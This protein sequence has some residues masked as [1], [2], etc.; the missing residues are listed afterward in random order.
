VWL[1]ST[2]NPLAYVDVYRLNYCTALLSWAKSKNPTFR[3]VNDSIYDAMHRLRVSGYRSVG[4]IAHSL[5]GLMV[6]SYITTVNET[7]G[8]PQRAQNAFVITLAT[9][10][11]GAQISNI[12][13]LLKRFLGIDDDLLRALETTTTFQE[14][15]LDWRKR[16]YMK[17]VNHGC[18]PVQLHA[19]IE[20]ALTDG[21]VSVVSAESAKDSIQKLVNDEVQVYKDKDHS[22]IAKPRD[23]T[24]EVF[25]WVNGELQKEYERISM[26]AQKHQGLEDPRSCVREPIVDAERSTKR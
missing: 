8:H 16:E 19:A 9:P 14:M 12:A 23:E 15:L 6:P 11:L 25:V 1:D 13:T 17:G 24:D 21:V 22:G 4:F 7:L 3:T 18:R 26:W 20:G 2:S 10:V 5:G